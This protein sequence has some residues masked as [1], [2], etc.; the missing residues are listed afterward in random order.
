M[1]STAIAH[2]REALA[3]VAVMPFNVRACEIRIDFDHHEIAL[4]GCRVVPTLGSSNF[5]SARRPGPHKGDCR[6]FGGARLQ[7]E[8]VTDTCT[9]SHAVSQ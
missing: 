1:I 3:L 7:N 9:E 2:Y 6:E 5:A 8:T 4:V